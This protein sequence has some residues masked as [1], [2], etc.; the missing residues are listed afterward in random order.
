MLYCI[1]NNIYIAGSPTGELVDA[2]SLCDNTTVAGEVKFMKGENRRDRTAGKKLRAFLS[3]LCL[4]AAVCAGI[5]YAD[6]AET[7]SGLYRNLQNG[8]FEDGQTFTNAYSQP[9]QSKVPYWNTTAFQGKIEL[10]RNNTG[11]Y[12]SGVQLTPTDGTYAAELNADEESTLYQVIKTSPS[13]VYQW[14]LDHGG[15]NG[16]DTMALIIGPKQPY[17]PSKPSKAGRDQLMQMVDWLIE[18]NQTSV[19]TKAGLGEQITVYSK[20]FAAK[21]TFEDNAGNNAFSLTPSSIYTEKWKIWIMASSRA[22]SGKNPWNPY[23]YNAVSSTGGSGGTGVDLDKYYFYSVPANQT[24]TLFCFVS[25]GYVDSTATP[26]KA[27]TY[28]NFID[29]INFEL[30]HPLSGSSTNHGVG[31]ISSSD[32]TS[33]GGGGSG[34]HTV[35]IDNK[36]ATFIN[37][38][39]TLTIQAV[40]KKDD[41]IHGCQFVGI[42]QTTTDD[43]GNPVT[44][45]I[46]TSGNEIEDTGSLTDEEKKGKWVK[47]LNKDG[48]TVYTYYLENLTSSTD[49]HF[50]FIKNPTITY[51]SNGG[52]PYEIENRPD[53]SEDKNVYSFKPH[54]ESITAASF[55]APYVS[56][57]AEGL[58]DGWK[59]MG[60][61]LTGDVVDVIPE[62]TEQVN[63]DKL[64][65]L[66]LPAV[67]S[68]ACDYTLSEVS[69]ANSEQYFKIYDGS[70]SFNEKVNKNEDNSVSGV[71]WLDG[72]MSK[73]YANVHKG[74]TMVAQW[75]WRQAFIPQITKNDVWTDSA[76]GGTVEI[77]SVTDTSN[78]NYNGA[79]NEN[80]GKSYHA[81]TDETVTVK[82]TA[83]KDWEFLG[84]YDESGNLISTNTEYG[85][86]ETKES[87]KTYYARFSN[88]VTQTYIRQIKNGDSWED[89]TDD[90]IGTLGRYTYTDAVGMPISSTASAGKGYYFVG[91]YDSEGN[92]VPDDMI[93][94]GG[95]TISYTT[96][97]DATYYARFRRLYTLTV[98]KIDGD[99]STAETKA[100]LAGVEFTLYQKDDSGNKTIVYNG[101]SVK[102]TAVQTVTT[103]LNSDRTKA[104]AVFE[105]KLLPEKEYYLAETNTPDDYIPIDKPVKITIDASESNV[106]IDDVSE[107]ITDNSVNIELTNYLK[108]ILPTAGSTVTGM[109][110]MA[111]GLILLLIASVCLRRIHL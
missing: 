1:G 33:A 70:I 110:Y 58:N 85:Y 2:A 44:A 71:T 31:I 84:W 17:A 38:G 55:I 14:G 100:P 22:T 8:S 20:K 45:F 39:D 69:G 61:K 47:S 64:G 42:Y 27:K 48:D 11:T 26:D 81:A 59:F 54:A 10:F 30:F 60:W 57:A 78:E 51:D 74:L 21:G 94:N 9:D 98:T 25:V 107:T 92:K 103:S 104:A 28:G 62:G 91:W 90:N 5:V 101:A 79:Y 15:R 89:T 52:K 35:T 18:K 95:V 72:N 96:T 19:K 111:A 56:K 106:L 93:T 108:L 87:V 77:T 97:D 12:I 3:R 73:L 99:S 24:E 80:G 29:N 102:C 46:K 109:W 50:I 53:E 43:E 86:I 4:I 6:A 82:A 7:E 88:S 41:A 32:G 65:S 34:S 66:L 16:T 13:S 67:H 75:R 63:A 68:V 83:K 23:G 49:V 36:L 37:D 105:Y 76:D 40:I